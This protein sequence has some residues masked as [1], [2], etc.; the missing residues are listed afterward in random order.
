M[1]KT[2][3]DER[4]IR[5]PGAL[6]EGDFLR[7]CIKCGECMKVC[8]TNVIQPALLEGGFEAIWTPVLIN[9]IGYCEYNCVLCG[10]VCPTGAIL[11]LTIEKKV[12]KPG[13]QKPLK[14]GTAFYDRGRCL[15]WAMN[16]ECIVCEEVC[17]T[18]PKAIWFQTF[19]LQQRD[20]SVKVLKRPYID[21]NLCTG[22]GICENK[23]P[24]RDKSAVRVT[25]I[26]ETRSSVNQMILKS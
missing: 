20:G 1:A 10:H 21:P 6:P 7:R 5:P 24:V 18:S 23:C 2:T 17:P 9:R 19:E 15:P 12:G 13:K 11:P 26:G 25:S 8:P 22:C 4:V 16:V 14:V 3:P